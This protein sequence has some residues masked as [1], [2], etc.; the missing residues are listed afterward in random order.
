MA[1]GQP[2]HMDQIKQANVGIV[3]RLIDQAGPVSRIDLSRLAQLAPGSITKLVREML[4]THLIRETEIPGG[5]HRGRPAIGLELDIDTW[6]YLSVRITKGKL[7]LAVF[8]MACRQCHSEQH[9]L[10]LQ[11]AEPLEARIS[12][13]VQRYCQQQRHNRL[14]AISVTLPG[15]VDSESGIVRHM[16]FY[17]V[18]DMPLGTHLHKATGL[19]VYIQHDIN[20]WTMTEMLFGA[21]RGARDV[22]QM[23]ISEQAGAGVISEGRLLHASSSSLVEIGHIQIQPQGI[24]CH[25][26]GRGC[27]ETLIS[28][29]HILTRCNLQLRQQ[30]SI[31]KGQPLTLE[32]L[33]D[34]ALQGDQLSRKLL[35]D[36]A[37]HSGKVLAMLINVFNP[38][39]ILLGS[40]F[41]RAASL[42]FPA[43]DQIIRQQTRPHYSQPVSVESTHFNYTDPMIGSARVKHAM[44]DGSLLIRLLHMDRFL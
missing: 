34:A 38:Q 19:T 25:C 17:Q 28:T 32:N 37:Q 1:D 5:G 7:C 35:D 27:L 44:Y 43:I 21:S 9:S 10:P 42:L 18:R 29:D 41:N 8:D 22:V 3:Y 24:P 36:I 16:A 26:G 23:V 14:I 4:Q 33:C 31:L 11:A 20:A 40:P 12:R 30:T 6:Y 2:G 13:L 39:K 15:V